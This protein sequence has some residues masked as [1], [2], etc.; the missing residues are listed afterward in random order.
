MLAHA[1][2]GREIEP[3]FGEPQYRDSMDLDPATE[4][5]IDAAVEALQG[6]LGAGLVGVYGFG[7][8]AWGDYQPGVSD[9]DLLAVTASSLSRAQKEELVRALAELAPRHPDCAGLEVYVLTED[10]VRRPTFPPSWELA[11][12]LFRSDGWAPDVDLGDSGGWS[13]AT[14]T[15]AMA[16]IR[17]AE[18]SIAG[19]SPGGLFGE[20]PDQWLRHAIRL[21]LEFWLGQERIPSMRTAVLNACRAWR[22]AET[23]VLG[24]KIAGG[25]WARKRVADPTMI[26]AALASQRGETAGDVEEDEIRSL[27]ATVM[28]RFG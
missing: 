20:I 15:L 26:D 18:S 5:L 4:R 2:R 19:A 16:I 1:D 9:V 12:G 3:A 17:R 6:H 7:S 28:G 27:M 21:E 11:V 23:G 13:D 25:E 22:F 14:P 8:L 10:A 24:S